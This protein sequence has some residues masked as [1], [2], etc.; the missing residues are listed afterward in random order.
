MPPSVW[1]SIEE[2]KCFASIRND[3]ERSRATREGL[4]STN[5]RGNQMNKISYQDYEEDLGAIQESEQ[6]FCVAFAV[7]KD[8]C[9]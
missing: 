5:L 6:S 4:L 1:F 9:D 8:T 7:V 2:G 3:I